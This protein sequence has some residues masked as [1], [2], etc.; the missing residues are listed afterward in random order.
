MRKFDHGK[1][2][3][4][5]DSTP[6]KGHDANYIVYYAIA[7]IITPGFSLGVLPQ[8]QLGFSRGKENHG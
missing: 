7:L 5:V 3:K 1:I 6:N 4:P 2:Y 8:K